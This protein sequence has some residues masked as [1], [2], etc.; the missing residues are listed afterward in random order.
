MEVELNTICT[1]IAIMQTDIRSQYQETLDMSHHGQPEVI[2]TVQTGNR[3]HP[4]ISIDPVFLQ[5]AYAHRSTSG[6]ARF[7]NINRDT[8]RNALLDYG[9]AEPQD[10]P[11]I[12]TPTGGLFGSTSEPDELLNP[13]IP[14]PDSLPT[15]IQDLSMPD[16]ALD[17]PNMDAPPTTSF[18]GPLS[19]MTD[20]ELDDI[21]LCLR[22]HYQCAGIS[23]LDGM[24]RHLG[25]RLPWECIRASLMRI[26]PIQ[27]VFQRIQ[28]RRRVYSVPG[29]MSLWH[30][31]GQH[32]M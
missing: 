15:D 17:N 2:C 21:L 27:H 13:D 8:V 12:S 23:M 1:N 32:G 25:H 22:S 7:L 24:L 6:I 9:I 30:H 11:F 14:L 16:T 5:W 4:Q 26:D 20:T 18:T 29:P 10:A 31:D 28:I 19:G 3:G